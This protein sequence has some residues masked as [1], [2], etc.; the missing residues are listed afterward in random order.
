MP[1]SATDK[2]YEALF[3]EWIVGMWLATEAQPTDNTVSVE[4]T[5]K[6]PYKASCYYT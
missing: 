6:S 4:P 2:I 5:S 1:R 3:Q